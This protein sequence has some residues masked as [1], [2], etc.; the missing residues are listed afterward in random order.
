MKFIEQC[1]G[2][3]LDNVPASK[4]LQDGWYLSRKFDGNYVQIHKIG[5]EVKFYTSGNKEFFIPEVANE[6]ITLNPEDSF[7]LECEYVGTSDGKLGDRT[8]ACKL[9]TYRTNFEKKLSTQFDSR[10]RFKAFDLII[11]NMSFEGREQIL[12]SLKLGNFIDKIIYFGPMTLNEAKDTAK[13]WCNQGY[14]GCYL[15]QTNHLQEAGKR[16]N[17]AIKLKYRKT[18]D[19]KC[20]SIIEGIGKYEGKIGSLVLKDSKGR[21]VAVGSGLSDFDRARNPEYYLNKIVEIEFEQIID[22]YIQPTFIRIR[23]DKEIED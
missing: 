12:D 3:D 6:L 21:I 22:T 14:E 10:E 15:K 7:I 19:L 11:S 2:K 20:I 8:K 1:K 16:V 17:T 18:I 4:L 5:K 13:L 9:T 23:D